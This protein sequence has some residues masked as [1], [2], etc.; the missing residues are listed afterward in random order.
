MN[1]IYDLAL[2]FMDVFDAYEFYEWNKDDTITYIQKIP[3]FPINSME[4]NNIFNSKIQVNYSFLNNIKNLTVIDNGY[5]EYV[6]LVTDFNRVLA[7]MFSN[8]GVLEKIS[9][10]L[11]DEEDAVIEEVKSSELYLLDYVVLEKY[12]Y[13]FLTRYE[14]K[15]QRFLL[16]SINKLYLNKNYDEI[17]Y[18]YNE[19]FI[20]KKRRIDYKYKC[21]ID[22][23]LN[24]Y[25]NRLISIY[26]I[27]KLAE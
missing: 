23:I 10:L 27:I 6:C 4:M 7:L 24:N 19:L 13:K 26:N 20:D 21:L 18:L 1:Y 3:I 14:N 15:T 25:D 5:L 17:N 16:D 22:Y 2:C 8:T 9:Y 11:F 12:S